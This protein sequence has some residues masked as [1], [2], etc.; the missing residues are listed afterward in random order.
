LAALVGGAGLA[1]P[2]RVLA[3]VEGPQLVFSP[4]AGGFLWTG[5]APP[6]RTDPAA[7]LRLALMPWA[8]L[9]VEGSLDLVPTRDQGGRFHRLAHLSAGALVSLRPYDRFDP[10]LGVGLSRLHVDRPGVGEEDWNGLE[11][12]AGVRM[13]LVAAEGRRVD[14]RVDLRRLLLDRPDPPDGA[15]ASPSAWALS[16]G[17]AFRMGGPE[18]D[19]D[20]DGVPDRDD[21]CPRTP[22]LAEVDGRGCPGDEDRDGI[23]DGLDQ[24]PGTPA[25]VQVDALGCPTD[26]DGDGVFDGPDRCPDTPAGLPVDA[27]GCPTDEDGDGVYDGLDQCPGTPAGVVVDRWGCPV[28]TSPKEIELL[29]TGLLRLDTVHFE[30]A[31]AELKPESFGALREVGEI[32]VRWPNLRIEIAGHTDSRGD[33][34]FN[35]QL[36]E[37]RARTVFRWLLAA[38]PAIDSTQ[39]EV[40]GYGESRSIATNDTAEGRARNRRVEFRVLNREVLER[41]ALDGSP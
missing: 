32:L 27:S 34:D 29:D 2:G 24:C 21:D 35:Q 15:D 8:H 17:F 1:V 14:L 23:F 33:E 30:S 31:K 12:A 3:E 37:E 5:D 10:Y 16:V 11:A 40:R 25:G 22:Y 28:P 39:Y 4:H 6:F 36:S 20:R 26:R 13:R 38:F 9:G 41:P 19:G 7:G 18:A